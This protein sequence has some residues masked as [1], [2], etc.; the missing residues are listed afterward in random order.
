MATS[1]CIYSET[2]NSLNFYKRD[3]VPSVGSTFE[4]RVVTKIYT[5]FESTKYTGS[6]HP[7][8]QKDGTIKNVITVDFVDVISPI[9]L[10]GWFRDGK[11]ITS[12]NLTNL[13]TSQCTTMTHT[14]RECNS[15]TYLD[16]SNFDT[17]K[18]TNMQCIFYNLNNLEEL[19]V[20]NFDTQLVKDMSYM[21]Y[22]CL[23]CNI[24]G[25]NSLKTN[26]VT[27]MQSMF[28]KC[29]SIKNFD[30][31]SWNTS[32]C[33]QMS[34]MFSYGAGSTI[35]LVGWD[36]SKVQKMTS[37]FAGSYFT[38]LD[39]STFSFES[40]T[41]G[42]S[43]FL[44]NEVLKTIVASHNWADTFSANADVWW[45]FE[46]CYALMGDV[47][48]LDLVD[49]NKPLEETY[50]FM[51]GAYATT[52]GG[53]LTM[54]YEESED[55]SD[56]DVDNTAYMVLGKTLTDIA[57]SMRKITGTP[58]KIALKNFSKILDKQI[59][60]AESASVTFKDRRFE[61]NDVTEVGNIH[62]I[63]TNFKYSNKDITRFI[64]LP[65]IIKGS[66]VTFTDMVSLEDGNGEIICSGD[67][68]KIDT[69]SFVINGDATIEIVEKE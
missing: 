26:N 32:K 55:G 58:T 51:A 23:Q 61:N 38:Y 10:D 27:T 4:N 22:G 59:N 37:M 33:T 53:Y 6:S 2:D 47:A 30:L 42:N 19:D 12:M 67:A 17:S 14:F 49:I 3:T 25:L 54:K 60:S 5:D 43:M 63:N 35:N 64:V 57:S 9:A 21:F 7:A 44:G 29:C 34:W 20:S 11:L 31:S 66:I 16:V 40:L 18:V 50:T 45:M 62:Y 56:N 13:D 48:Y 28:Y 46:N 1:F 41:N 52:N 36:T 15:L 24:I 65:A 39:L 8:W 68:E 69:A